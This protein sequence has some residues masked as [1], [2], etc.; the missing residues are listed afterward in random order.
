MVDTSI[1]DEVKA[2]AGQAFT[3]ARESQVEIN[4]LSDEADQLIADYQEVSKVVDNLRV[5]NAGYRRTIAEQE[6]VIAQYEQSIAE[7]AEL[8]RQIPPLMERMQVALEQFIELDMP[9]QLETRRAR[10]AQIRDTFDD[11]SVNIAEKFRLVLTAYQIEN[12]YGRTI[13]AYTDTLELNGV[14]RDV[15]M[16]QVGRI[17][18]LYQTSDLTDTGMWD[19]DAQQWV[20]LGNAYTRNVRTAIRMAQDLV[21]QDMIELPIPAPESAQ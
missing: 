4:R 18:L 10:L 5:Y 1:I 3:A 20:S 2:I 8:Q 9:F 16:L 11:S 6:R 17:A 13:D 15:D 12:N 19:K 14:E 7:A 21:T